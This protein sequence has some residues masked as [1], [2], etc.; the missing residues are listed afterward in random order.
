MTAFEID[1]LWTSTANIARILQQNS[2]R[3]E[4]KIDFSAQSVEGV[5]TSLI[6]I[7]KGKAGVITGARNVG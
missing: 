7:Q 1:H 3:A 6:F 2:A 4:E 5:N